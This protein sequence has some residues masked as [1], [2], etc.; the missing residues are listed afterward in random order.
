MSLRSHFA[1]HSCDPYLR[2]V[3]VAKAD[4]SQYA[5]F[6]IHPCDPLIVSMISGCGQGLTFCSMPHFLH[7][8]ALLQ[9]FVFLQSNVHRK[10][11]HGDR[12]HPRLTVRP[13]V[14]V[15]GETTL[16]VV[17]RTR[18]G[19]RTV[20]TRTWAVPVGPVSM[21]IFLCYVARSQT[22][23]CVLHIVT[24]CKALHYIT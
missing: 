18:T 5:A 4:I 24:Q 6:S 17:P 1:I 19:R 20:Q 14:R 3:G 11:T 15:R 7:C 22:Y 10:S 23:H 12:H 13:P 21:R 16:E 9:S 2:S 8:V